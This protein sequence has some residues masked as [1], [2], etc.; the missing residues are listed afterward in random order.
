MS[1]KRY[2]PS[3]SYKTKTRKEVLENAEKLFE[4]R[5]KI[6]NAFR[7][8]IFQLAKDVQ[9]KSHQRS[10]PCLDSRPKNELQNVIKKIRS[11]TD[12]TVIDKKEN[13]IK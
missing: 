8:D 11:H 7:D 4:T 1:L 6:I 13:C 5:N 3:N 10:K 2:D 9:K 12:L